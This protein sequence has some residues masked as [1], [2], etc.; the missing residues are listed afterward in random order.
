MQHCMMIKRVKYWFSAF[1]IMCATLYKS[2]DDK[3]LK[4]SMENRTGYP[5]TNCIRSVH[6]G[7]RYAKIHIRQN[8]LIPGKLQ[9]TATPF[10]WRCWIKQFLLHS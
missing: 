8:I 7:A 3:E 5:A 4:C 9:Y 2:S 10:P 1:Y 6:E